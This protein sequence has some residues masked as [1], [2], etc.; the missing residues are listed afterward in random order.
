MC[1][2]A[3]DDAAVVRAAALAL[4]EAAALAL[5]GGGQAAPGAAAL[6]LPGRGQA[7]PG[8]AVAGAAA[9]ASIRAA[10]DAAAAAP[11]MADCRRYRCAATA[12][13]L[14]RVAIR[15]VRQQRSMMETDASTEPPSVGCLGRRPRATLRV[16][17]GR[18]T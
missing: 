6:A 2:G 17:G 7:A 3:K 18:E 8:A 10:A 14:Q 12:G 11:A 5:P 1:A 15:Q 4:P 13:A 9:G 16:G